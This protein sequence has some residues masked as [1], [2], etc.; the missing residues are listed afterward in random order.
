MERIFAA[1]FFFASLAP[2]IALADAQA[3][4]CIADQAVGFTYDKNLSAWKSTFFGVKDERYFLKL[5]DKHWRW[6]KLGS[7]VESAC[8]DFTS[9]GTIG[10][11]GTEEVLFNRTTLRYQLYY[12]FG[13]I[14]QMT[15]E[16]FEGSDTPYIEIGRCSAM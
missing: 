10:C 1:I 2:A 7:S 16:S 9:A 14:A 15:F 8:N 4:L 5:K 11:V 12:P 13:Y 6:S 3:Y